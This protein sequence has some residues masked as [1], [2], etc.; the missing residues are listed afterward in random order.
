MSSTIPE[1]TKIHQEAQRRGVSYTR[2]LAEKHGLLQKGKASKTMK[3]KMD[4]TTKKGMIRDVNGKRKK[5]RRAY[6]K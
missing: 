5:G 1:N 3:G 6:M 4:F 2:L